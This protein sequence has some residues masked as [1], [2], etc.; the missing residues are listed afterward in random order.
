MD[1]FAGRAAVKFATRV[2]WYRIL[3]VCCWCAVGAE[4]MPS[5]NAADFPGVN[6]GEKIHAAAASLPAGGTVD[7]TSLTGA[8]SIT[9]DIFADIHVPITLLLGDTVVACMKVGP[10]WCIQIPK[11]GNITIKGHGRGKTVLKLPPLG[12]MQVRLIATAEGAPNLEIT[13]LALDGNS[14]NL[15]PLMQ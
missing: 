9:T 7:A 3:L 1:D 12:A 15:D 11:T 6:L 14:E 13:G 2:G 4:S 10:S 8:Q 5:R